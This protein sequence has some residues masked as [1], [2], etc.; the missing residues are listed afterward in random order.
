MNTARTSSSRGRDEND[1]ARRFG[2]V[3]AADVQ[4]WVQNAKA[5]R[6]T[7]EDIDR[8]VTVIWRLEDE[9][10]YAECRWAWVLFAPSF[11]T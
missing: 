8:R 10:K 9:M 4:S 11:E 6:Q 2:I 7:R 1:A 5:C 3:Y